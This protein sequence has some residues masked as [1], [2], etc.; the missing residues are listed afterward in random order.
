M[1]V[2]PQFSVTHPTPRIS[3]IEEISGVI[4]KII[5]KLDYKKIWINPDCG[6]KTRTLEEVEQSLKNMTEAV[7]IKRKI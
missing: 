3:S 4:D 1:L 6:L 7:K 5:D 2:L